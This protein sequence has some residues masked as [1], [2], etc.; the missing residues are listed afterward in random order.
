MNK[1]RANSAEDLIDD[2]EREY[3]SIIRALDDIAARSQRAQAGEMPEGE[4]VIVAA[5]NA[6][7]SRVRLRLIAYARSKGGAAFA[8]VMKPFD[9][10]I[11]GNVVRLRPH[12]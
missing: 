6:E 9:D 5:L 3:R 11:G 8:R 4:E 1:R 12:R 2:Q 10:H 7:L